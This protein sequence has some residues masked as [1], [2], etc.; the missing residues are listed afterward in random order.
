MNKIITIFI[1]LIAVVALAGVFLLFNSG[2][3][4]HSEHMHSHINEESSDSSGC[5]MNPPCS[6]CNESANEWNNFEAGDCKCAQL[7]ALGKEPCSECQGHGGE[8]NTCSLDVS[9][10]CKIDIDFDNL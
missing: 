6:M 10:S 9:S 7:V 2:K 1:S 8:S 3:D 5:C 4:D